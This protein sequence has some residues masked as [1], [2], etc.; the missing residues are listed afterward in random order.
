MKLTKSGRIDV[1][2]DKKMRDIMQER[3][4]K[5]LA[6]FKPTELGL[7]EATRLMLKCPSWQLVEKELRCMPKNRKNG[8]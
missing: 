4:L 3:Y 2:W 8:K 5:K 1:E 7:P 6:R